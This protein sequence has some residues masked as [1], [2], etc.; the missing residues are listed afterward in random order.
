MIIKNEVPDTTYEQKNG[1]YVK[2]NKSIIQ[3]FGSTFEK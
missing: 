2:E 3:P 1:M